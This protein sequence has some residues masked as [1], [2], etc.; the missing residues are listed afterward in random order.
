M[1]YRY[2][3]RVYRR[4]DDALVLGFILRGVYPYRIARDG[5]RWVL[6]TIVAEGDFDALSRCL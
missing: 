5:R 6:T 3:R 4:R 2:V 1:L